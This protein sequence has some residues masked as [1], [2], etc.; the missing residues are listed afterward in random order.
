MQFR[1]DCPLT[2]PL[3][4]TCKVILP[5]NS[6]RSSEYRPGLSRAQYSV[7]NPAELI[8]VFAGVFEL[9]MRENTTAPATTP[10]ER[11]LRARFK[12]IG[13]YAQERERLVR[14]RVHANRTLA[15]IANTLCHEMYHSLITVRADER[16]AV[17]QQPF[18]AGGHL[19]APIFYRSIATSMPGQVSA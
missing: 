15:A 8:T 14:E 13:A 5:F 4:W 16:G 9:L 18:D 2:C 11:D 3:K 7:E 6:A 19:K 10:E 17:A 12:T 1:T